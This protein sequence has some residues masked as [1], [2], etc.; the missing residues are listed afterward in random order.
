MT[1]AAER[2]PQCGALVSLV[3]VHGHGECPV[4]HGNVEPC[5]AGA[6]DEVTASGLGNE[7]FAPKLFETVFARLGGPKV[8]V[9]TDA[10]LH[11]LVEILDIDLDAARD[12]LT[13]GE[14]V[15][16][17]RRAG[18]GCHRLGALP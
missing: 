15:G 8:T 18:E 3:H 6:G 10:L 5:C 7:P 17:V 13:A 12:V 1:S 14:H 2:C 16:A 9:T 11:V 4:C